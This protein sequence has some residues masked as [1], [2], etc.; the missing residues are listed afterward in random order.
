M[1]KDIAMAAC[2]LLHPGR[3]QAHAGRQE[4]PG[5][6]FEMLYLDSNV[7]EAFAVLFQEPG[8]HRI[9]GSALQQLNTGVAERQ[10]GH[11]HLLLRNILKTLEGNPQGLLIKLQS[12]VERPHGNPDMVELHGPPV[13]FR[14]NPYRCWLRPTWRRIS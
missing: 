5:A 13:S 8:N 6:L 12:R 9:S 14:M 7:V 2:S 4:F 11:A 3:H 10:H 1:N